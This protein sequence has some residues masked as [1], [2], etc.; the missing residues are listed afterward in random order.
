MKYYSKLVAAFLSL[1]LIMTFVP[2]A[3]SLS[4]YAEDEDEPYTV[5]AQQE[6]INRDEEL[7]VYTAP[8]LPFMYSFPDYMK[9]V[10]VTP[11]VDFP[12]ADEEGTPLSNEQIDAGVTDL[13]DRVAEQGLNTIIVATSADSV[14]YSTDVNET[15]EKSVVEYII[16]PAKAR[17]LFVYLEFE[18]DTLLNSLTDISI[19]NRINQFAIDVRNFTFKYPCDGI[20]LDGYYASKSGVSLSDYMTGG[21][22]IGY[23]NWLSENNSYIFS[24][25]AAAVHKTDNTIPVGI[26]LNDVWLNYSSV[27]DSDD[28][29]TE[30]IEGAMEP[31]E[32]G[33]PT[34]ADFE[35]LEDGY[36]DTLS[37]IQ[38]GYADFMFVKTDASIGD[39]DVPFKSITGWW[40]EQATAAGIPMYVS[41]ANEK[42]CTENTG[43]YSPDELVKQV[44][45]AK[46]L[47]SC[48]GSA[49]NSLPAL[50][51]D[52][53][54]STTALQNFYNNSLDVA[55]LD[56]E[57]EMTLPTSREYKT[58]EPTA[59]F[60]GSFDPNFPIFFQGEPVELN[61]AGRF[62]FTV[63]LEVGVNTFK[64]QSKAKAVTYKITRTVQVLRSMYP[65]EGPLYVDG[66]T[67]INISAI[68][69]RGSSVTAAINGKN[70]T[71]KETDGQSEG[72]D[73]NSY[74]SRFSG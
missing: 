28:E 36:A 55:G 19:E 37:Y 58:E 5:I 8:D 40:D 65:A 68:A 44:I 38:N 7:P 74:Y 23:D 4:L 45:A 24:L 29:S 56:S 71:L 61:E 17:G 72:L 42:V 50:K 47:T 54:E 52:R 57:L 20:V 9:G 35:A 59:I 67:T 53:G 69:Y 13:L 73:P 63:D 70:I 62:Y 51:R 11:G 46:E 33:S 60:A 16:S 49:F 10:F 12:L 39:P 18:I 32:A 31:S 26:A 27:T 66:E 25:A 22:G 6:D 34:S 14:F 15:V 30:S 21:S 41:H 1:A 64:L 48:K 3:D 43:W 2:P